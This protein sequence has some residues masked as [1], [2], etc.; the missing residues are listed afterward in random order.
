MRK[1]LFL[2]TFFAVLLLGACTTPRQTQTQENPQ[3]SLQATAPMNTEK[4]SEVLA[5]AA[6]TA[7]LEPA[8]T[9]FQTSAEPMPGCTVAGKMIE[10]NPTVT[11]LFP[12]VSESDWVL[13]PNDAAATFIEYGDFQ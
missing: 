7:T 3:I 9:D 10:P 13:G 11:A 1:T 6:P 2:F 12:A 4:P 8:P 5:T